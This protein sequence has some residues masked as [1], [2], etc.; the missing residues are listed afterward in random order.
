MNR[1][2]FFGK[3]E[4]KR[5]KKI[6]CYILFRL[7]FETSNYSSRAVKVKAILFFL[8]FFFTSHC[9]IRIFMR[10][11]RIIYYIVRKELNSFLWFI[12]PFYYWRCRQEFQSFLHWTYLLFS[13]LLPN[14]YFTLSL[15]CRPP[16]QALKQDD[17]H[18]VIRFRGNFIPF[19]FY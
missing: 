3:S 10:K 15:L 9:W 19:Y 2:Y 17:S 1:R 5:T 6:N 8:F 12:L 11:E 16:I 7:N 14:I 18:N 4:N 13:P